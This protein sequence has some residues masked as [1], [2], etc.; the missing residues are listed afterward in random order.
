MKAIAKK[1]I[2]CIV[3]MAMLLVNAV[4]VSAAGEADQ[5]FGQKAYSFLQEINALGARIAGSEQEIQA[6]DM[7]VN[8]LE[9]AGYENVEVQPFSYTR[10]GKTTNSQNV[11]VTKP[12]DSEKQIIIGAHYDSVQKKTDVDGVFSTGVD[13]NGSGT[14]V[15]LESALR[16]VGVDTKYTLK[17]IFFGAE[18]TGLQGSKAYVQS[19]SQQE[20][21]NTVLMINL[22]S[23]LAGDK[24]YIYGGVKQSDGTVKDTWAFEQSMA[25]VQEL[26]LDIHQNPGK[27]SYYPAPSTGD[28]SDHASFKNV[29]I[30]YV[31]FEAGNWDLPPYDGSNQ[32][33][34]LGEIMHTKYDR[35]EAVES[36]FGD[37]GK[38]HLSAFSELLYNMLLH[39]DASQPVVTGAPASG[40][41]RVSVKLTADKDVSWNVN[42]VDT[43]RVGKAISFTQ[44][45]DY[46]VVATDTYGIASDP[47][48]FSI[49]RV[50]PVLT[51]EQV[52]NQGITNQDV[53]LTATESVQFTVDGVA[54]DGYVD[55]ITVTEPGR[56]VVKAYDKAG[57]YSGAYVFT[58]DK[59]APVLSTNFFILNGVTRYNVAVT[60]DERADFYINGEL[61]DD[62]ALR[63]KFT[64]PGV[65]EVKAV[66]AAGNE[67]NIIAFEIKR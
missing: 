8:E 59:K 52:A 57:N 39:I 16:M 4:I 61:A 34:L 1:S 31:Y 9:A 44:D 45:G 11:I 5:K 32:T 38:E 28:W 7:L 3:V 48:I 21:D 26:G 6:K 19:M 30:T 46:T 56:H 62:N 60:S 65:Y 67:S 41:H 25:L 33:E 63:C 49:D 27:N 51:S 23:I 14:S 2:A 43:G 55:T 58:I 42:G 50:K 24:M 22:D 20:L 66:D 47:I 54:V 36:Y 12:G 18:E 35:L 17:F 13:D 10:G 37:R 53:T 15:T 40:A 29:G 64:A